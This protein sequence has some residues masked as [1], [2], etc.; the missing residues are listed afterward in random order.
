MAYQAKRQFPREKQCEGVRL[1]T[2]AGVEFATIEDLSLGGVRLYTDRNFTLGSL[3]ELEF[4]LRSAE[5][6]KI[7]GEIKT[8]GRV[9]R[10]RSKGNGYDTGVQF[11]RVSEVVRRTIELA[12]DCQEGEF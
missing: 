3:I 11:I 4:S 1:L 10:S 12:I 9:T 8:L 6:G 7:L 5:T 2:D